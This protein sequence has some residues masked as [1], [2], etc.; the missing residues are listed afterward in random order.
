MK[1]SV[2][3]QTILEDVKERHDHPTAEMIYASVQRKVPNISLGTVYR[4]LNQLVE[5]GIIKKIATMQGGDRFDYKMEDHA[6]VHC[7]VCNQLFDLPYES[8]HAIDR[9]I[10]DETGYHV[11]SYDIVFRGICHECQKKREGEIKA[12]SSSEILRLEEQT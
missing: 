5:H 10:E 6:H 4:N 3:R 12:F 2:Q 9:T 7:T 1:Y 11:L 8:L